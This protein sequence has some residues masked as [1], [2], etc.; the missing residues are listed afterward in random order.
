MAGNGYAFPMKP[1]NYIFKETLEGIICRTFDITTQELLGRY[2]RKHVVYARHFYRYCLKIFTAYNLVYIAKIT[3]CKQHGTVLHSID[4]AANLM[5][6]D[7]DYRVKCEQI[8]RKIE[9][10]LIIMPKRK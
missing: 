8:I 1:Q 6:T 9:N 7:T 2:N 10:N 3:N 5:A 4:T